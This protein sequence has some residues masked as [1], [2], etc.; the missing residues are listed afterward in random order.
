M[1]PNITETVSQNKHRVFTELTNAEKRNTIVSK[2]HIKSIKEWKVIEVITTFALHC[3]VNVYHMI[4]SRNEAD[5]T[6]NKEHK[7]LYTWHGQAYYHNA[8]N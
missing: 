8:S 3:Q 7:C 5:E 1:L 2:A 6:R 4:R